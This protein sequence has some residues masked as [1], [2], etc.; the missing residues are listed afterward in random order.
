[1]VQSECAES[2]KAIPQIAVILNHVLKGCSLRAQVSWIIPTQISIALT[3]SPHSLSPS[4]TSPLSLCQTGKLPSYWSPP[5]S[6]RCRPLPK[7][8]SWGQSLNLW[9]AG[10]WTLPTECNWDLRKLNTSQ[11]QNFSLGSRE[12]ILSSG[13]LTLT[14]SAGQSHHHRPSRLSCTP[15]ASQWLL[16]GSA[17]S[18]TSKTAVN[19]FCCRPRLWNDTRFIFLRV[20]HCR[21]ELLNFD[22]R[23]KTINTGNKTIQTTEC[24]KDKRHCWSQISQEARS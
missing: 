23:H 14:W 24:F 17:F 13:P 2:A 21:G 6:E 8:L 20:T 18:L 4:L 12:G 7:A 15:T 11:A 3:I 22:G 1:M 16:R 19:S 5:T 9:A 10:V